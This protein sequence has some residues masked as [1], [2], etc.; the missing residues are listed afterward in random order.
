[1]TLRLLCCLV[2]CCCLC[3]IFS[4]KTLAAR[5]A[6]L[7]KSS[8][9]SAFLEALESSYAE[10]HS[11]PN[12]I[13]FLKE[14]LNLAKQ[15]QLALGK[16]RT[17]FLLGSNY[18]AHAQ[19]PL[20]IDHLRNALALYKVL[21][22]ASEQ[23][24]CFN[25][26][27]LTWFYQA[28]YEEA[29][30]YLDSALHL[31]KQQNDS[32]NIARV[33][34]NL[35]LIHQKIGEHQK[36]TQYFVDGI[37]YQV[38]YASLVDQSNSDVQNSKLYKNPHVVGQ[39][40][41][42]TRTEMRKA[43][44][45]GSFKEFV[46]TMGDL[47]TLYQLLDQH[48]TAFFYLRKSAELYD[49]LGLISNY[50]LD[51]LDIGDS[52]T[53][54]AQWEKGSEIYQEL[55]PKMESERMIAVLGNVLEK[56]AAI[57]INL[58]NYRNAINWYKQAILLND[59][60]GHIASVAKVN[61][62]IAE[63]YL[64]TP[65]LEKAKEYAWK[66]RA[67]AQEINSFT[68][69]KR[70]AKLLSTIHEAQN[71]SDSALHYQKIYAEI[72]LTEKTAESQRIAKELEAN[73]E[74][75]SKANEI[76]NLDLELQQ[77]SSFI[78]RQIKYLIVLIIAT[79]SLVFLSIVTIRR[80]RKIKELNLQIAKRNT[81]NEALLKE[82]HHRVKNNLQMI[83]SLI[84]MQERR[85]GTGP[86]TEVLYQTRSR[87]KS[88]GLLHEQLY[89]FQ[90]Y[91]KTRVKPYIETLTKLILDTSDAKGRVHLE[92]DIDEFELESEELLIIGLVI[93]EL[94]TNA[95]KY[96]FPNQENATVQVRMKIDGSDLKVE[97]E[98]NGIGFS[99][100]NKGL[101]WTIVEAMTKNLDGELQLKSQEGTFVSIVLKNLIQR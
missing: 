29:I 8:R 35:G 39:L 95:L 14:Q 50:L 2:I 78:N 15:Q 62:G 46:G 11:Y 72:A 23:G 20:A 57:E 53:A 9:D 82:V 60:V 63:C 54:L 81:E 86:Q 47:G 12:Q 64:Q 52:Y 87:I 74:L 22:V 55:I 3:V 83:T 92:L 1:M 61:L 49:S 13:A 67:I 5:T 21:D 27:G 19:Y 94:L 101:G 79:V 45:A 91:A 68:M 97:L 80:N 75:T 90:E 31:F 16:A 58:K 66:G 30:V 99:T 41:E 42:E 33:L 73:Y 26:L 84:N 70:S 93:N 34:N 56:L 37:A 38:K 98:D 69:K 25:T 59:S 36:S 51:M 24:A 6:Q 7:G 48:D 28:K 96:A 76:K 10:L 85:T 4:H 71:Q 65:E 89:T 77:K 17:H 100:T 32:S 18:W 43:K 40:I 88:I 44:N